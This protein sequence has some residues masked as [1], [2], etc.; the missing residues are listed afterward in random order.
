MDVNVEKGVI[1]LLL[2][3]QLGL[4]RMEEEFPKWSQWERSSRS[5]EEHES[6]LFGCI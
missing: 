3:M 6:N 4:I 5:G 2:V 1:F